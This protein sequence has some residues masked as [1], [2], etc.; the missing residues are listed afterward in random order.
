MSGPTEALKSIPKVE[1]VIAWA[2]EDLDLQEHTHSRLLKAVRQ[3]LAQ[4]REDL[5]NKRL[6][7]IPDDQ[8][9]LSLVRARALDLKRAQLRP[10]INATGI[11]LHTNLGRAPLAVEALER[12]TLVAGSYSN[13][14]YDCVT[15]QRS[16]RQKPVEDLLMDLTGAEAAMVVNN[17]AAALFLL[18]VT[19]AK[20]RRAL[21]SRGELVEIGGSF[22]LAD[23]I[24]AA[25]ARLLEVGSTNQTRLTDYR[26]ALVEDDIALVLKV[27][28]ANFKQI[29]YSGQAEIEELAP[30]AHLNSLP[31]VVDLGSGTLL[32][33]SPLGLQET[34][35]KKA[36][37]QGA[38]VVSF[39]G[40]KLLGGPQAGLIVGSR[41]LVCQLKS[42]PLARTVRPDKM[43]LA[44][45]EATLILAQDPEEA[46]KRIPI[47]R[48]LSLT[49]E[50][51]KNQASRLKRILGPFPGLRLYLARVESQAGGGAA[52]EQPLPSWAV[53]IESLVNN[54]ALLE[55]RLRYQKTAVVARVN[56]DRLLLDVRTI[57]PADF[58]TVKTSLTQAW[59]E[60]VGSPYTVPSHVDT[61]EKESR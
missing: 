59:A 38:D 31:L 19:L 13:L 30:L 3:V 17:N 14:E 36:L 1:K 24:E 39:S 52:P 54:I 23:I 22:R 12:V 55:E 8:R 16:D 11:V 45:L 46:K 15:G 28:A 2:Q 51:L 26:Q 53:A 61:P 50:E 5:L 47:W 10:L 7:A 18:M 9:I 43:T 42:H 49:E 33:L 40:D 32:D 60:L 35:I 41:A 25:G 44:A 48:A 37:A 20:G 6:E 29:G 27:H 4:L 21:I 34:P 58:P 56:R 57:D